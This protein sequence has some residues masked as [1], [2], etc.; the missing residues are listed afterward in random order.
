MKLHYTLRTLDPVIVS[1][2][3]AT[4]NN[5]ECLD[6]IPGSAILGA[7]ASRHYS[8]MEDNRSWHAFHS[9]QTRFSPCYPV[10]NH[11]LCLPTPASWHFP[12]GASVIE[13]G[14]YNKAAISNQAAA[15]FR[16]DSGVQYKQ[17]RDGY[18]NAQ[19]DAGIVRQ[20]ITTKTALDAL[21]GKARESQLFSYSCIEAGQQF[22]GWIDSDD[23]SVLEELKQS[24]NGVLR[25]GR[26]RNTE[27]GRVE[28]KL[29]TVPAPVAP[30][31]H[32]NRLVLWCLSDCECLSDTGLPT[33]TPD[34]HSLVPDAEGHLIEKN[35]FIRSSVISRFNQKRQGLDSEQALINK[36][37]VLV[38][39]LTRPLTGAQLNTLAEQGI[40]INRQQGLGWVS[41]N[42]E[43]AVRATLADTPLFNALPLTEP[44][45]GIRAMTED[46]AL[47][48]WVK[49]RLNL[50]RD[51]D[52]QQ[53]SASQLLEE[54][55]RAYRNA[56]KYN[57]IVIS[58]E[59]GP[60]SSQWRRIEEKTRNAADKWSEDVFTGEQAICKSEGDELGWGIQWDNGDRLITFAHCAEQ[61]LADQ[62]LATMRLLLEKLGRHDL[63]TW[64]GLIAC[65]KEFKI[66]TGHHGETES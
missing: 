56:R 24:L 2:N 60:S 47:T 3:N 26:S 52:K 6:Y 23:D 12:K 41:V 9:G 28:L 34:L 42:P 50:N 13:N 21:K 17:C 10:H 66:N 43:W 61:L 19:G 55:V 4:T 14:R 37:S 62:P 40:G 65:E 18:I 11:R 64:R 27:F 38:Y 31:K 22:S 57:H 35:S 45:G 44:D 36:G 51:A 15:D 7:L 20:S 49:Q 58:N 33:L 25:I 46:S 30:A 5:H 16:R 1:Q 32:K 59:A 54:I 8:T 29:I 63:S 39:K 53:E 48:D